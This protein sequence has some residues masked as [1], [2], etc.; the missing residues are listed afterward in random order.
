MKKLISMLL[1]VLMVVGMFPVSA[2]A[3]ENPTI[4]LTSG[5]SE[6]KIG[7]TIEVTAAVA[8]NPGFSSMVLSLQYDEEVL[9]FIGIKK[10][11][12]PER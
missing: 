10:D 4:T 1:A 5:V 11:H 6:A 9:K 8:N 7:D 12:L 2:L 3:E